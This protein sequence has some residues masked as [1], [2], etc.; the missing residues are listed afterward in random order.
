MT[1]GAC[2]AYLVDVM[3]SRSS[4]IL[5]TIESVLFILILP[6]FNSKDSLGLFFSVLCSTLIALS[7]AAF[8]PMINTFGIAVTNVLFAVLVWITFM[9]VNIHFSNSF[10]LIMKL[11]I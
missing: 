1:F 2:V 6:I 5:A 3:H 10:L 7:V 8:L 9:Y 11:G 4:E